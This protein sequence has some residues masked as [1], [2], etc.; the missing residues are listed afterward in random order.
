M[1]PDMVNTYGGEPGT[2]G[3]TAHWVGN[4]KVGE[5]QMTI[6]GLEAPNKMLV[7]LDFVK[8]FKANNKVEFVVTPSGDGSNVTWR[9]ASKNT[10]MAKVMTFF[11]KS[12]D[13]M[14]G[15]DFEKGLSSLKTLAES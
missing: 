4:R 2:V 1:D 6:T 10:F 15:P 3:S 11:G 12:M 9:M 5:G 13:K 8:P 7:D 14:V